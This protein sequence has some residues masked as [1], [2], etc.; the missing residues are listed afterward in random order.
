MGGKSSKQV[1]KTAGEPHRGAL[2]HTLVEHTDNVLCCTFSSDGKYFASCS[3]DKSI[4]I[5]DFQPMRLLHLIKSHKEEVTAVSFSPDNSALVSCGK[6]SK[7]CVW[8]VQKGTKIYSSHLY[9]FGALMDC[10]FSLDSNKVFATASEVDI[11]ML[12]KVGQQEV[13]KTLLEGHR[14]CVNHLSFSPDNIHLAS[15]GEDQKIILWNK[16][17][18]KILATLKDKY[19]SIRYCRYNTDG[20]L[21]A[22]VVYGERVKIWS[23]ITNDIVFILE[24]HHLQPIYACT[25]SPDGSII[26]TVSGD[27]TFALWDVSEPHSPPI[28]H[29]KAHDDIIQTVAISPDGI[30]LA[31]GGNDNK[32]HIW[33]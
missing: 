31:T 27:T 18:G 24:G 21:I 1:K 14:G 32:I 10:K 12:W 25:F 5:W 2:M 30:Y 11:V 33:V 19:N 23:T 6:D 26:A 3:S 28:Y 8:D 9:Q 16:S 7:V 4:I 13:K 20:T 29:S 17:S 15:C 22:A